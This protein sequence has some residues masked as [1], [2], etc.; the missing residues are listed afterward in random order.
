[1]KKTYRDIWYE[2]TIS[3]IFLNYSQK[4]E[5]MTHKNSSIDFPR[6]TRTYFF[7]VRFVSDS[8]VSKMALLTPYW[9]L[10]GLLVLSS[11]M[12]GVYM[13]V[14]RRFKYWS[15]RGIKE[16]PP[17]PFVGNFAD[18]IFLRKTSSEFMKEMYDKAKGLLGIGFY[19]F[20]KPYLMVRDLE[21]LKHIMVKDFNYFADRHATADKVDDRLGYANL[22]MIKNPSWKPLRT[23]LTPIFTSGKLKK[24]F[25]L[26]LTNADD[27]GK[28]LDSMHLGSK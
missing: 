25:E 24:M 21:L 10:D 26:M 3:P 2:Q 4:Y 27:L 9:G 6:Q 1:M 20:D 23:K 18:C 16:D 22:F 11:L 17:R 12:I 19:I 14:T 5:I 13:Y 7:F 28:F 15:K 8:I